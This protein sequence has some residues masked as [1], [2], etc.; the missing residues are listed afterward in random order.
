MFEYHNIKYFYITN[1]KRTNSFNSE[2]EQK[3]DAFFLNNFSKNSNNDS[4]QYKVQLIKYYFLCDANTVNP[5][6][7]LVLT[8]CFSKISRVETE[9][10][11]FSFSLLKRVLV[12]RVSQMN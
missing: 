3:L 1:R 4:L 7:Q 5:F 10:L 8:I 12:V 2:L 6:T 11:F 9:V